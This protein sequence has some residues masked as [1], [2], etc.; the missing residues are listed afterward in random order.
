MATWFFSPFVFFLFSFWPDV[1]VSVFFFAERRQQNTTTQRAFGLGET[2]WWWWWKM[3]LHST[4]SSLSLSLSLTHFIALSLSHTHA[5]TKPLL[6]LRSNIALDFHK[7]TFW[8]LRF[9]FFRFCCCRFS[10]SDGGFRNFFIHRHHH[11]YHRP[12]DYHHYSLREGSL[13]CCT[14]S[15]QNVVRLANLCRPTKKWCRFSFPIFLLKRLIFTPVV[16]CFKGLCFV[17]PR[18]ELC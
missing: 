9:D 5:H 14:K 6:F 17:A 3:F 8:S 1:L 13:Y 11:H 2:D 15:H 16:D 12:I 10:F 4:R 7:I 18:L